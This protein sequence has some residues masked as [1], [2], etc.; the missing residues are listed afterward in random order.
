[1]VK[2]KVQA[3]KA[4]QYDDGIEMVQKALNGEIVIFISKYFNAPHEV[5]FKDQDGEMAVEVYNMA[6]CINILQ[7]QKN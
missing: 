1:M 6:I 5:I 3:Y 7:G 4:T 2:L